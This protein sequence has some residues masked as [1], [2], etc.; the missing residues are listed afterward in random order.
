[1]TDEQALFQTILEHPDDDAP[2]LVYADWLEEHGD[3][4]RAEFI[5]TQI[6][7]HRT[8]ENDARRKD[9]ESRAEAL[10]RTH[11]RAWRAPFKVRYEIRRGFIESVGMTIDDY[12][13]YSDELFRL[14][15]ITR[16]AL[17]H[18][19]T[20]AD[21]RTIAASPHLGRV[22]S[23][24]LSY[25]LFV[26]DEPLEILFSSAHLTGLRDL[27]LRDNHLGPGRLAPL[28]ATDLPNLTSLDLSA[29]P[30]GDEGVRA[31][32]GSPISA[33]LTVLHLG[34]DS[35]FPYV[36]CIHAAG[37]QAIAQSRHLC[38][39]RE[40]GL[41]AHFIGDGG[42]AAL[43]ESPNTANLVH[44]DVANNDIGAIGDSG[45][46]AAVRSPHLAQLRT[47]DFRGNQFGTL[48]VRALLG[49]EQLPRMKW[50]DLRTCRVSDEG[51]D[52]LRSSPLAGRVL[53]LE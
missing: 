43:A 13:R 3:A 11:R 38:S 33:G 25:N 31:L 45:I 52:L 39:L 12:R 40:L 15:P 29:N 53:K 30:I 4:E 37:T 51:Y 2:R 5:R 26:G 47:F 48:G 1:M 28:L 35:L 50:V 36:N 46:E 17:I 22:R 24:D 10:L 9:L 27:S 34:S 20:E 7:A 18:L 21:A 42:L 14:A 49:W 8:E 16:L 23:L 6:E 44:L 41:S 32:A 19:R